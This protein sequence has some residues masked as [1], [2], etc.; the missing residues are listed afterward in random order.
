M[1]QFLGS[2]ALFPYTYAPRGWARCEGQL[3]QIAQ[4]QALF[5]LLGTQFGGDGQKTFA[6]PKLAGPA[7]NLNYC[8]A[9]EGVF[10]SQ[11]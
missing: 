7:P 1:E 8:V 5:A 4:N 11:G 3:L 6:L 10:P 9:L 2:I